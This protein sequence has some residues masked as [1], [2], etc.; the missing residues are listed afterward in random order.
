MD[1]CLGILEQESLL[2]ASMP[3]MFFLSINSDT[4]PASSTLLDGYSAAGITYGRFQHHSTVDSS[5][6]Q[7]FTF[8]SQL[9]NAPAHCTFVFDGKDRANVKRGTK[10]VYSQP[11]LYQKSQELIKAF[12]FDIHNVRTPLY[13]VLSSY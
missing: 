9:S 3:G 13:R 1:S 7:L 8:L 5:L 10:V 12:G 2:L 6:V 4:N 11:L